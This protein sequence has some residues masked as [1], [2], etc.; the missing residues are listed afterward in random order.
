MQSPPQL[1]P[2]TKEIAL[3]VRPPASVSS[4]VERNINVIGSR[5]S[6]LTQY[7]DWLESRGGFD[8]LET[9]LQTRANGVI[10]VDDGD[11]AEARDI[12]EVAFATWSGYKGGPAGPTGVYAQS[13][14]DDYRGY[15]T[16]N[17]VSGADADAHVQVIK[18]LFSAQQ[19]FI[20]AVV[21]DLGSYSALETWLQN[22][23]WS[24][25]E[26]TALTDKLKTQYTWTELENA[27]SGE[28]TLSIL[29]NAFDHGTET[30]P[31]GAGLTVDGT[32][33][34]IRGSRIDFEQ[35]GSAGVS[36]TDPPEPLSWTMQTSG[37]TIDQGDGVAI[38]ATG[39]APSSTADWTASVSL[40]VDGQVSETKQVEVTGGSASVTFTFFA[41]IPGNYEVVVGDSSPITITVRASLG[42][43]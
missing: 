39:A 11:A 23:G 32:E 20:D 15:L 8:E 41:P 1:D 36:T 38:T 33:V 3:G 9:D 16:S 31:G 27:L 5:L 14:F 42:V 6:G 34:I 30:N 43:I 17:G 25:D 4:S 2:K 7:Q 13:S 26:A 28:R 10:E 35:L 40:T 29:A 22:R 37:Q 12:V 21:N 24:Q 18:R 19:V